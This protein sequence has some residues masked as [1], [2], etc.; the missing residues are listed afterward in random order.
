MREVATTL[1]DL[2]LSG[3]C[4]ALAA[5][6]VGRQSWR[7]LPGAA[8]FFAGMSLAT[9]AGGIW[10]GFFSAT[11]GEV[12]DRVWFLSMLCSGVAS[13][14]LA[15]IGAQLLG[16]PWRPALVLVTALLALYAIVAWRDPRFLVALLASALGIVACVAGCVAGWRRGTR[17]AWLLLAGIG[18]ALVAAV[19]QQLGVAIHPVRFDHNATYHVGLAAALVLMYAAC[20]RMVEM[21]PCPG[22]R[23]W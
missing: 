1:T 12:A 10:H 22:G 14:G 21:S 7:R 2:L 18:V 9:L 11:P 5:Q 23:L 3:L 20:R 13:A 15:L 4:A 8:I 17:G 16:A 6:L 19:G